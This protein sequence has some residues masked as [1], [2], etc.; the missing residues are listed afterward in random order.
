MLPNKAALYKQRHCLQGFVRTK[1]LLAAEFFHTICAGVCRVIKLPHDRSSTGVRARYRVYKLPVAVDLRWKAPCKSTRTLEQSLVC[2]ALPEVY[3][4]P[5]CT[6]EAIAI[7]APY[8]WRSSSHK[9]TL[10][11]QNKRQDTITT[12]I[13]CLCSFL[14][15]VPSSPSVEFPINKKRIRTL[16]RKEPGSST[17]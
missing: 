12:M 7:N 6:Y 13:P 17:N 4:L 14:F 16:S 10:I 2:Y 9:A 8:K 1:A 3:R 15:T 11:P 5:V